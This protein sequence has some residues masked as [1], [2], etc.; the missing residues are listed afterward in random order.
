LL[1]L[2]HSDGLVFRHP[3]H[4]N[5]ASGEKYALHLAGLK[6]KAFGTRGQFLV[7]KPSPTIIKE[8]CGKLQLMKLRD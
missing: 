4:I 8:N 3:Q 7:A 6:S 5:L 2:S 1:T